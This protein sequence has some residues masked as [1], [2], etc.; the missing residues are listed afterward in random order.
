MRGILILESLGHHIPPPFKHV[1]FTIWEQLLLLCVHSPTRS[2][3]V[4]ERLCTLLVADLPAIF[5][6]V[7]AS[8]DDGPE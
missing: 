2:Q 7:F 3:D 6:D 1:V 4:T 5:R 8:I